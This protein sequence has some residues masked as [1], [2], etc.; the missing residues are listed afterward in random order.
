MK[1]ESFDEDDDDDDD[2][3]DDHNDDSTDNGNDSGND[4]III[5]MTMT[6]PSWWSQGVSKEIQRLSA[7][8]YFGEMALITKKK[9]QATVTASGKIRCGRIEGGT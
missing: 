9:R 7:G 8:S 5:M 2:H 6:I 1:I 3:S 4:T